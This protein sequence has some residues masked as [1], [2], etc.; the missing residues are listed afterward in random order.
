MVIF[1]FHINFSFIIIIKFVVG[2]YYGYGSQRRNELLRSC[3]ILGIPKEH[4]FID[5]NRYCI[6]CIN[7][8][9]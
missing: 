4:V 5:D 8:Y 2:N 1:E 9:I 6:K 3:E 7:C